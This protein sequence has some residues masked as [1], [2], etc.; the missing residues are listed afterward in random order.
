MH[1][2][3]F[4]VLR[5]FRWFGI[6]FNISGFFITVPIII[7]KDLQMS[8]LSTISFILNKKVN[9]KPAKNKSF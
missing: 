3:T 4:L 8:I 2:Y 7:F 9:K 1:A 5:W 6:N